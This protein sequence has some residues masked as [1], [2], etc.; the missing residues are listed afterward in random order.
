MN[1]K[2]RRWNSSLKSQKTRKMWRDSKE[3]H[4]KTTRTL[5]TSVRTSQNCGNGNLNQKNNSMIVQIEGLKAENTKLKKNWKPLPS[6]NPQ[7]WLREQLKEL[8][9]KKKELWGTQGRRIRQKKGMWKESGSLC[10]VWIQHHWA[11]RA[12]EGKE[13]EALKEIREKEPEEARKESEQP[14]ANM[15]DS[16]N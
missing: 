4:R 5:R 3:P 16:R 7:S 12:A 8:E 11:E 15:E 1:L 9:K 6:K 2:S 10:S 14:K 13:N